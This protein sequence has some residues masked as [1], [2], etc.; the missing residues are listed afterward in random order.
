M[1]T[2]LGFPLTSVTFP[3]WLEGGQQ[4]PSLV[5]TDEN[6]VAPL[7][8]KSLKL[9]ERLFPIQQNYGG[10]YIDV[11]SLVNRNG[12]GILQQLKPLEDEIFERSFRKQEAWRK[13][14][15]RSCEIPAFTNELNELITE[16][17]LTMFGL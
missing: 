4:Q 12:T 3:L 15:E 9:K 17:Y 2:I 16:R 8:E 6:G 11:T 5:T 10:N 14:K 1:W 7:C 13:N